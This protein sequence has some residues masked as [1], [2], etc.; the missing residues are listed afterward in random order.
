MAG[1][2][3]ILHVPMPKTV[4]S[5][6]HLVIRSVGGK[7]IEPPSS[8][9]RD[10]CVVAVVEDTENSMK[11]IN[12]PIGCCCLYFRDDAQK[13]ETRDPGEDNGIFMMRQKQGMSTRSF[14]IKLPRES[15]LVMPMEDTGISR[16]ENIYQSHT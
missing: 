15:G 2:V 6:C 13:S 1:P 7:Y 4:I 11:D 8:A 12:P 3:L 14:Q 16:V 9:L 5:T 10:M